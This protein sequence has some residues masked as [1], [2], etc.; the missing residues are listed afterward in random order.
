MMIDKARGVGGSQ[1]I[2]LY[3]EQLKYTY[4]I[5]FPVTEWRDI[6]IRRCDISWLWHITAVTDRGV[7]DYKQ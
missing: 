2:Q 6:C 1:W 7:N 3:A 4:A 5:S